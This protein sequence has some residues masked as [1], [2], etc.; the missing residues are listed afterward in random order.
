MPEKTQRR[1]ISDYFEVK[2]SV[3]R[4]ESETFFEI[5]LFLPQNDRLLLWKPRGEILTD[6][7]L[8]KYRLKGVQSVWVHRSELNEFHRYLNFKKT[9]PA[10]SDPV[11]QALFSTGIESIHRQAIVS[12][13]AKAQLKDLFNS[14]DDAE[15]KSKEQ[16]AVKTVKEVLDHVLDE[17]D[18]AVQ[19]L[20]K[21]ACME[22]RVEHATRV[23]TYSV[24]IALA[25][26]R[27]D[28]ELLA[29]L[30][31]ASLLHDIGFSR[32]NRDLAQIQLDAAS[33]L[34]MRSYEA[35]VKDGLQTLNR[36]APALPKRVLFIIE[37][38]HEKFDG[39]GYPARLQGFQIDD[40]ASLLAFS[41]FLDDISS[42][43]WDGKERTL[44]ESIDFLEKTERSRTFPERFNPELFAAILKW[45]KSDASSE[46][47]NKAVE[48][49]KDQ[50]QGLMNQGSKKNG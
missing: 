48:M 16:T 22:P 38:H 10:S 43:R 2:L 49:I 17:A 44:F 46:Q 24:L 27:I 1:E 8:E 9:K 35:H 41:D 47:M 50:T 6:S 45:V 31:L 37:Q 15:Q 19:E 28:P 20:W 26:G 4:A 13:K 12:E 32:L 11:T 40:I 3:F 30:G 21:L 5:F 42:G 14:S 25:F 36:L 29:D 33:A 18:S 39:N 34:E 23:A 7:F